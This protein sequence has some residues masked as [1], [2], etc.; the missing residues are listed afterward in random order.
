MSIPVW[1]LLEKGQ[2]DS[3]TIEEAISRLIDAHNEDEESHVGTGQSLKSHKAS[4][5]ID[6]LVSSIVSSAIK[7]GEVTV[8]KL[9]WD[10]FF[11]MPELESL[12]GWDQTKEGVGSDIIL[13]CIG[14]VHLVAGNAVGNKSILYLN[15]ADLL[16]F[17]RDDPALQVL[18]SDDGNWQQD[19]GIAIGYRDPF[20]ILHKMAGIKYIKADGR[21]YA[22]YVYES[23]GNYYE[24]QQEISAEIPF[25]QVWRVEIDNT[26]KLVRCFIDGVLLAS[27]DTSAHWPNLSSQDFFSIGCRNASVGNNP[28]LSISNPLFYKKW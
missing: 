19:I 22:F 21:A 13:E 11:L 28:V 7:D 26:N 1:G 24:V 12:D 4:V 8:P 6:H 18:V 17:D 3:E 20:D 23:G 9:G 10:R 27:M 2:D 14:C 16:V 5:I 15:H 25:D